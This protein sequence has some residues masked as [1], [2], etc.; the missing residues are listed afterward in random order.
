ME[1]F[2]AA[3]ALFAPNFAACSMI[4]ENLVSILALFFFLVYN[5]FLSFLKSDKPIAFGSDQKQ[6]FLLM[7]LK[8]IIHF[9]GCQDFHIFF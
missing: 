1:S 7:I 6:L 5:K 9:Y 4:R 2:G 8:F 3:Q